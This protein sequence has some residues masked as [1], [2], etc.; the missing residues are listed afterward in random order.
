MIVPIIGMIAGLALI[1]Y[2]YIGTQLENLDDNDHED[3][4]YYL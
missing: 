3:Y 4:S 2:A 1:A